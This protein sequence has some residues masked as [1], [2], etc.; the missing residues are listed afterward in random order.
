[1]VR[2][3]LVPVALGGHGAHV[4]RAAWLA[5]HSGAE[6]ILL[7]ITP[8]GQDAAED[9]DEKARLMAAMDGRDISVKWADATGPQE[10]LNFARA[11]RVDLIVM[12]TDPKWHMESGSTQDR[13]FQRFLL[14]SIEAKV[15]QESPCPVWLEPV[16]SSASMTLS[17]LVC[18]LDLKGNGERL[19][20][21]A[22]RMADA[23]ETQ[24]VLFH[25]TVST[26]IFAP[27]QPRN[28]V[29]LQRYHVEMAQSRI[30]QLQARCSTSAP[31]IVAIGDEVQAL[32][33]ALKEMASPLVVLDRVSDRWG[34]NHKIFQIMRHCRAPVLIRAET[35]QSPKPV[36]RPRKSIDP[37]FL[38]LAAIGIGA[39]LIY[40][41]MYL[42][43]HTDQ[44][45]FAAIRCQ[46]PMDVLFP[47]NTSP[48]N[49]P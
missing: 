23:C 2:S 26:R 13:A 15:V 36:L 35:M 7:R 46:T 17:R 48:T 14:K 1:M 16:S 25:S 22:S 49:T 3:I 37:F 18:V 38:L 34:D 9:E 21:F 31:R 39:C 10:I 6:M 43:A 44:C 19:I 41:A 45:H 11:E 42:A 24:L 30:D 29:E 47:S 27:G 20:G 33:N 40:L 8:D 28:V 12:A 4:T 5:R 32:R